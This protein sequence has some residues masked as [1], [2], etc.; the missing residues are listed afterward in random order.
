MPPCHDAEVALQAG[1]SAGRHRGQ[2]RAAQV[3][4]KQ[5]IPQQTLVNW[6]KAVK[7]VADNGKPAKPE[8]ME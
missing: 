6:R 4:R 8:Q 2:E 1:G 3:A 5:G 7:L